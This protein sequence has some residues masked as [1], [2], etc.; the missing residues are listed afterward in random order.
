MSKERL[1]AKVGAIHSKPA[2][3]KFKEIGADEVVLSLLEDGL[4]LQFED[5]SEVASIEKRNNAS[6]RDMPSQVRE[7]LAKWETK[8]YIRRTTRS[9]IDAVL[10][11]T[12]ARRK[13][14]TTKQWKYRLCLDCTGESGN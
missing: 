5:Y 9:E 14:H 10:P 6:A 13:V 4:L 11:L 2:I 7:I 1:E 3:D 12:L 8:G